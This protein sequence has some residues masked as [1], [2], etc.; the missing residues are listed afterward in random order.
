MIF[1]TYE[2]SQILQTSYRRAYRIAEVLE[3]PKEKEHNRLVYILDANHP[4]VLSINI[5]RGNAKP[6]YSIS[7]LAMIW[8]YHGHPYSKERVRQALNE[9]DVP[10]ENKENKG[11][12]YLI[13]IV[14]I[15][16]A[17]AWWT[18]SHRRIAKM[19]TKPII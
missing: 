12:V 18:S 3:F 16:G 11:L 15:A 10:I 19:Q 8:E 9:F 14:S 6:L 13:D 17:T 4:L 1:N 2:L 7:E 5:V